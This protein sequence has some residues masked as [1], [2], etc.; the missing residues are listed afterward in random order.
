MKACRGGEDG[1]RR[2]DR[3]RLAERLAAGEPCSDLGT[4]VLFAVEYAADGDQHGLAH[5][6]LRDVTAGAGDAP[7]KTT[8]IINRAATLVINFQF[9]IYPYLSFLLFDY[10]NLLAAGSMM[11]SGGMI[12]MDEDDCMVNF[13]KFYLEFIVE[14]SCGKCTPCRDGTKR[15]HELLTK[16]TDGKATLEDLE[17]IKELSAIVKDSSLCGLGQTAPNPILSTMDKFYDEYMSH[18]VDK[19]CPAGKCKAL[20]QYV[21]D[22]VNCIGCAAC[23][24]VCPVNAITGE[25]KQTHVINSDMCIKC[26]LCFQTCKFSA[27]SKN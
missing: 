4:H 12:V 1:R 20:L 8:T 13:A 11:G 21:I 7:T 5:L 25:L 6:L 16:I 22:D 19:K 15:L 17:L 2:S 27:I 23:K 26:D 14:E 24:K 9:F 18:I 10:E 3:R